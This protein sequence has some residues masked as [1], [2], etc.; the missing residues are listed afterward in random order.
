[1]RGEGTERGYWRRRRIGR[2]GKIEKSEKKLRTS[3]KRMLKKGKIS[4][5]PRKRKT[6]RKQRSY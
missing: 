2:I 6:G 4:M 1:L 5:M 3:A